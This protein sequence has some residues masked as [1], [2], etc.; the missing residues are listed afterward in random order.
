MN[1]KVKL[2]PPPPWIS[3]DMVSLLPRDA[4][5]L[6]L[7]G[8]PCDWWSS[9]EKKVVRVLNKGAAVNMD[10]PCRRTRVIKKL[11]SIAREFF[12]VPDTDK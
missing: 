11:A 10:G 12:E 3:I 6:D 4:E 1:G 8:Q 9:L 7:I 5:I 2:A